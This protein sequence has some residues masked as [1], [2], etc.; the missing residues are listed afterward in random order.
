DDLEKALLAP[1]GEHPA[2][3][4]NAMSAD[5]VRWAHIQRVFDDNNGNVSE[6]ARRLGM[7]RRTLQRMLAKR[8]IK[9]AA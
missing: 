2:P 1:E 5:E 9:S 7:H 6:T 4:E 3:P 8:S